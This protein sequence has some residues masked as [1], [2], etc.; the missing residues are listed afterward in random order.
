L[1][2][3]I[4]SNKKMVFI[5]P[6]CVL[7][8][9][10]LNFLSIICLVPILLGFT[11][12]SEIKFDQISIG[13]GLS[14]N[15]VLS[16]AQDRRG[17]M[18]IGTQDGLNRYDGN[19]VK[20]FKNDP[21][22]PQSLSNSYV[23][24]IFTDQAGSLW[25]GTANGL[26]RFNPGSERF[27]RYLN[28]PNNKNSIS[29]NNITVI[30]QDRNGTLWVGT[31]DS[32]LNK[33]DAQTGNFKRYQHIENNFTTISHNNIRSI[34]EDHSGILWIGTYGGG[35]NRLNRKTGDFFN[36]K[37]NPQDRHS[38]SHENI[39]SIYEDSNNNLWVGTD[40]GG[41]DQLNRELDQFIHYKVS[42]NDTNSISHNSITNIYEDKT[43]ILWIGTSGG[44]INTFDRQNKKFTR[45][46][47][48]SGDNQSLSTNITT[49]ILED[50]AGILWFGT[51]N[52]ISKFD[53]FKLKF[54]HYKHHPGKVNGL[55]GNTVTAILQ[56]QSGALWVGT[57][58][59][60]LNKF[61]KQK[62]GFI[63][64]K[65]DPDDFKS[66]GDGSIYSVFEDQSGRIW[67]G[68]Q[69]GGL[70]QFDPET[71]TFIRYRHDS[72]KENSLSHDFV[73]PIYEDSLGFLWIGTWGG[74]LNRFTPETGQFIQY[75]NNPD[76]MNSLSNDQLASILEDS[77]GQI[78]IGTFQ[79]LNVLDP[80]T[81]MFKHF[82]NDPKD[83]ESLS[84]NAAI[85][86]CEDR[87][88]ILWVGTLGG[89]N[90]FDRETKTFVHYDKRDGL[91]NEVITSIV[92]DN[93]GMLWLSSFNGISKFD[94]IK[95]IFTN[96]NV[97]DG[98][99]SKR[100]KANAHFKAEDGQIFFG[101]I[102]GFNA[103]YPEKIKDNTY[104]PS[105]VLTD[106]QLFN[107]SVEPTAKGVLSQSITESNQVTLS[108]KDSVFSL[109]FASLHF[110]SPEAIQYA[111]KLEGFDKDWLFTNARKRFAT[112]TNL[113][114]GTYTFKVKGT[115]SDG[116]WT[117]KNSAITIVIQPPFW[118]TNWFY[119]LL[120]CIV[121]AM[122]GV[123]ILY[124]QK[125][126]H[127]IIERGY[128]EKRLIES[129]NRYRSLLENQTELVCRYKADGVFT[130]VNQVYCDFFNKSKSEL[131]GKRWHPLPVDDD[132][133]II[134]EKRMTLSPSN[135]T[136]IIENRVYA[137]TG[138]IHWVQFVNRAFFDQTGKLLEIQSV[139]RDI[140]ER[141]KIEEALFQSETYLR[142]L[143]FSIPDLVWLKDENGFY[144][145]CNSKFELLYGAKEKE[146]I[147]KT[148]YDF[149]DKELAD[150]FREHDKL[151]MTKGGP[152]IN[153]EQVTYAND[154]HRKMLETIKTPIYGSDDKLV[155]VLG[156]A[157]DITERIRAEE[158]RKKLESQLRQSHKMEAVGT[159][160]GGIAHDFNNILGIIIGNME[161]AIDSIEAWNPARSNL[162]E[163][164]KA[165]LR[166]SDVVRQL[167]NFS[168]KT[169]QSK[170][171]V[172][173]SLLVK[174]SIKL[175]RSSIPASIDIQLNIPDALKTINA[176]PTQVHQVL[177]NLCTNAAHA[178]ENDGGVL[179]IDLSEAELDN[180]TV[181]Q[182]GEIESG[183]YVLLAISDTGP[184]I[185]SENKANIFDPYFT[186]KAVGKGTGMGLAVVLGI[187]KNHN[188]AIS[189][190]SEPGK[191]ST[192][193]VL[194]PVADEIA[195]EDKPI[196]Q[197]LPK[198]KES[199]LFIDDE[200]GLA[201]I[202]S[203]MLE[204][205]G[206]RVVIK[207]DPTI[208]L[209][210]F[211]SDPSQFDLVITDMT[212][213]HLSGEELIKEVLKINSKVPII[214]CTG[215]SNKIDHDRA[216]EIGAHSYIEKPLDK[217]ILANSVR[218]AL[219]K[220]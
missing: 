81:G 14:E 176:D 107:K 20:I 108:Y 52:G 96:Y 17:F 175:L 164:K 97:D 13:E 51:E 197:D 37:P 187:V 57:Q 43:G 27:T 131:I 78:W 142:T 161:L 15:V 99:Q 23:S 182:F 167:L 114:G 31:G 42:P 191:G 189:V 127:E 87:T 177:I 76:N 55:S 152:S 1:I 157:R 98:L 91:P 106:F 46:T 7:Y 11:Q 66:I 83:P 6:R 70:N 179:K 199:I 111:Y 186:T 100:F 140:T 166:A 150:S 69:N 72:K 138:K 79:G 213:P 2:A 136:I 75:K 156:V 215:F 206:Y 28:D 162:E 33:F 32:G 64:Y 144:L 93:Q 10:I 211:R 90:R 67:I 154:G 16:L 217:N 158:E 53:R 212:M 209:E 30:Y 153:E 4:M 173:I 63:H 200:E 85:S 147:G 174:E 21:D 216:I 95:E 159:I 40:G 59:G 137:G 141:K 18:W 165:G 195:N 12:I 171:T 205:L 188:G 9:C 183:H 113:D 71:E 110:S 115:N 39:I 151:A 192:F 135:Q 203:N 208:A 61:D 88:G 204:R 103:F 169:E 139:G 116:V 5:N 65:H 196:L 104:I 124:L 45:Y 128:A 54:P 194:F 8:I 60:G 22:D 121:F 143:I 168:R 178:M 220:D 25:V 19:Q 119:L 117:E 129:E 34:F 77:K 125:L 41:L 130:F 134:E 58:N 170:K 94:P 202:G 118:K 105:I 44:G 29:S 172:D 74:G 184:G 101:G 47:H 80:K 219:D 148:D 73:W 26:N 120:F 185:D 86:L 109:E 207:T 218:E 214:L 193:K 201:K 132:L 92:E 48:D 123:T 89:L 36:Y 133:E 160:A 190:Y 3:V 155:G 210:V 84:N 122:V 102:N 49:A 181:T 198:G 149:V 146:I 50:S 62:N 145:F 24:V 56:N 82:L 35:L 112:Y 163:I 180:A 126:R 38:I 68:T